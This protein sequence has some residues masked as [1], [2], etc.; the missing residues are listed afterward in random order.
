MHSIIVSALGF[1]SATFGVARL[2]GDRYDQLHV[3]ADGA[4]RLISM[5]SV[6]LVLPAML[7]LFDKV[8]IHT[9]LG[10]RKRQSEP[11]S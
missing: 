2:F 6:I 10:F 1:F 3:H 11:G 9:S 4:G 8:I 5:V 7:M